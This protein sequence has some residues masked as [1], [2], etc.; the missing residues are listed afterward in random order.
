MQSKLLNESAGLRTFVVVLSTGDEV[1]A[2]LQRFAEAERLSAAQ[3]T[4]L[5]AFETAKLQFFEWETKEYRDNPVGEQT[6]VA[7]LVGDVALDDAGRPSLHL[8]AVLGRR[9]GS[10]IAGH[11]AEGRVRPTLEVIL[12]ETPAHL[13]RLKDAETGLALIRPQ[14]GGDGS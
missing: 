1:M 3:V 7:T 2:C 8:H 5:G 10:A 14:A 12:T 9:D 4:A 13:R 11:L 6:E